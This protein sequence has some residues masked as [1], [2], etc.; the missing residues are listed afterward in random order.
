MPNAPRAPKPRT[1]RR[2]SW[3]K[4]ERLRASRPGTPSSTSP[5]LAPSRAAASGSSCVIETAIGSSGS[6]ISEREP[7]TMITSG[8]AWTGPGAGSAAS[9][10]A[11]DPAGSGC[12]GCPFAS[13]GL[14][15]RAEPLG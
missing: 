9:A 1:D 3:A 15:G 10:G 2:R 12:S 6:G 4:F 14:A 11:G 13:A 5:R 7:V 8:A